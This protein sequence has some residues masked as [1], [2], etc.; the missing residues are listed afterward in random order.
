MLSALVQ[1]LAAATQAAI[2]EAQHT[3]RCAEQVAGRFDTDWVRASPALATLSPEVRRQCTELKRFLFSQLY[4]HPQ[5]MQMTDR[6]RTVVTELFS[7]YLDRPGE[8]S[9]DFAASQDRP[10]AVADYIAG[11]T[12]RF[13]LREHHRLTG[14]RLFADAGV[15]L[16]AAR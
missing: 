11:M 4:R 6:A 2:L 16:E 7:A 9:T 15:A 12:D 14:Q 13:A 3:T 10:R 5:V 1:D 8:M